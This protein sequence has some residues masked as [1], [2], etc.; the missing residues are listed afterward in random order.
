MEDK[1]KKDFLGK[2]TRMVRQE[3][4]D[5]DDRVKAYFH[6][7]ISLIPWLGLHISKHSDQ[8]STLQMVKCKMP[9]ITIQGGDSPG[10]MTEDR[11]ELYMGG[12]IN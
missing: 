10:R 1:I 2:K 8:G 6:E 5:H 9:T 11:M 7:L 3:V 4:C 12:V